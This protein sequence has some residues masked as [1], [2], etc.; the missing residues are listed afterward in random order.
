MT[1]RVVVR[2]G[3]LTPSEAAAIAAVVDLVDREA[4]RPPE[5]PDRRPWRL[6]ALRELTGHARHTAPHHLRRR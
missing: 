4:D 6:A 1:R 2:G 3:P 5:Q